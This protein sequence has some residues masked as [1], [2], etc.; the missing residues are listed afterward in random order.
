MASLTLI[1]YKSKLKL[2][3]KSMAAFKQTTFRFPRV[4]GKYQLPGEEKKIRRV[5]LSFPCT[6]QIVG[7]HEEE[8]CNI[9]S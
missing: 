9:C 8:F 5:F 2:K 1:K 7:I 3:G 4:G 6:W